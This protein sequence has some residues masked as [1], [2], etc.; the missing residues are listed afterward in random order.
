M[1]MSFLFCE[2]LWGAFVKFNGSDC[3]FLFLP[4]IQSS[5][6][7]QD[8]DTVCRISQ[9][10]VKNKLK[11]LSRRFDIVGANDLIDLISKTLWT[12]H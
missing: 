7:G 1:V 3:I 10:L 6:L 9:S 2:V 4:D 5:H 11:V 8:T 12:K